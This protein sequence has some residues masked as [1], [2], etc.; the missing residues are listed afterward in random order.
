MKKVLI[1][2]MGI[3]LAMGAQAASVDWSYKVTG[4]AKDAYASGYT[5]YL[6]EKATWTAAVTD[7][8]TAT[9]FNSALDSSA[10]SYEGK[11][12][13]TSSYRY[14]TSDLGGSAGGVRTLTKDAWTSGTAYDFYVVLVNGN[15][16]P[17]QYIATATSITARGEQ[18]SANTTGNFSTTS[19]S[20]TSWTPVSSGGG[21]VP[22][23]TS[24]LLL[25]VGG[26]MLALRRKQK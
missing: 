6:F 17:A 12:M 22:E 7:G 11:G 19:A 20:L 14:A 10:L 25:L 9:T 5:A 24:G 4:A 1:A 15:E 21:D 3:A 8:I 26:A 13:G 16:D 18:D 23:P 2:I